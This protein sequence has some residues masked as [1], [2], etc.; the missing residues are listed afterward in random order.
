MGPL[1]VTLR[2][3]TWHDKMAAHLQ[4][5]RRRTPSWA[6]VVRFCLARPDLQDPAARHAVGPAAGGIR[7]M[8]PMISGVEELRA[9]KAVLREVRDGLTARACSRPRHQD[10]LHG[11][12]PRPSCWPTT[13]PRVRLLQHRH[14]RPDPTPRRTGATRRRLLY[15]PA[16][17]AVLRLCAA[18]LPP[19]ARRVSLRHLRRD[20]R[21]PALHRG[22]GRP[23]VTSMSMALSL[24]TVRA[25]LAMIPPRRPALAE[26]ALR[27]PTAAEMEN[28]SAAATR[29]ARPV[30]SDTGNDRSPRHITVLGSTGSIGRNARR[31]APDPGGLCG[32][33]AGGKRQWDLPPR[34]AS[35]QV[36]AVHD[37]GP[38]PNSGK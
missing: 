4:T 23:G 14:Q 24:P 22:P 10:R 11:R 37:R 13:C 7:I 33:R 29:R 34:Y 8:L 31:G 16:H 21:R 18:S 12:G 19:P 30:P 38:P 20:G 32:G 17:P 6:G 28:S 5:P 27:L 36:V 2:T 3:M 25:E 1:T 15:E 35:F 26:Q 9:V